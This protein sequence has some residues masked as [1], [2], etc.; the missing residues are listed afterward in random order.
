M[1]CQMIFRTGTGNRTPC[2]NS[3][4]YTMR[5]C[6]NESATLKHGR[7]QW[8]ATPSDKFVLRL[9]YNFEIWTQKVPQII[10]RFYLTELRKHTHT[11]KNKEHYHSQRVERHVLATPMRGAVK[12]FSG[13]RPVFEHFLEEIQCCPE[14]TAKQLFSDQM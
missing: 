14:K 10:L 4:N 7:G 6:Q 11:H 8:A 9:T 12:F 3:S 1:L 2:Q 13:R 5:H